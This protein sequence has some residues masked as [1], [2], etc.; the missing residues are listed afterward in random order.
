VSQAGARGRLVRLLIGL[1]ISA[2]FV[3]ATVS[4][5]DLVEVGVALQRVQFLGVALA[6]PLVFVELTLRA[7]RWQRLLAPLTAIPVW[8]SA[9]YL[10]IGYFANSMLPA[11]LGDV[12]RAY[13][14]GQSFGVSRLGVLGTVVVE[15]LADGLLILGVVAVLGITVAGGG[16]L[17]TTASWLV[18]L[19]AAGGAGLLVAIAYLRGSGTGRIRV[20]MRSLMERVLRGADALRS[21]SG[22]AVVAALTVVAFVPA[23][24]MFS[25]IAAAAGLQLSLAQCALAMGGLALSTSIP[26]APGSIG[27][28]EFVGLTILSALG[29]DA[30]VALAVVLLV[31]LAATLPV[32]LAGLVA[33]WQLH[34][35]VSEIA[36]DSEPANLARDDLPGA[37]APADR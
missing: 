20:G 23:V 2:V 14:A 27:T 17:A 33:A 7:L 22:L 3:V 29:V 36:Q 30:E 16:S 24:A 15:R 31:H 28:Y 9:A 11:R 12:A 32:A 1:A 8:R 37:A 10:A 34:F 21:P 5:V 26:A 25:L 18:V 6:I 4:R 19:A 13:L 35:R